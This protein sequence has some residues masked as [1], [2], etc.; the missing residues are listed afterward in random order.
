MS[1]QSASK[2]ESASDKDMLEHAWRYFA[3]HAQQRIAV[4]NFFLILSGLVAA[5]LAACIQR[6]DRFQLLGV[7]LGLLLALVSFIFWKLD[8]RTSFLVKH[9]EGAIAEL[10]RLLPNAAARLVLNERGR[11]QV[12]ISSRNRLSSVWTYGLAFRVVF[13]TMGIVGVGG[14]FLCLFQYE[15]WIK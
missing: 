15:S 9:G 13:T 5:G 6:R 2:R 7:F 1:E 3:L 4:F 8:Q 12:A 11:T 14:A 10:E